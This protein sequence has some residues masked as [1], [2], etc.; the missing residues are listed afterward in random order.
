MRRTCPVDI[1]SEDITMTAP[2]PKLQ[3]AFA[4]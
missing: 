2:L 1:Q 3:Q 4:R